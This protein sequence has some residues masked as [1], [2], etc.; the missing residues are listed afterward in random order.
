MTELERK[1]NNLVEDYQEN[2]IL[3]KSI[4]FPETAYE[5]T[6]ATAEDIVEGKT[7]YSN[8][9]LLEG[10]LKINT[11]NVVLDFSKITNTTT[12]NML[13]LNPAVISV[14]EA[15]LENYA[16]GIFSKCSNMKSI[17]NLTLKNATEIA[18]LFHTCSS[19]VTLP[20]FDTTGVIDMRAMCNNCT[21]LVSVPIY[22]TSKLRSG[23]LYYTFGNCPN[24]SDESLNNIMQM[25][26][27]SPINYEGYMCLQ[28]VGL[29]SSQIEKCRTLSNYSAFIAAGWREY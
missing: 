16:I 13:R 21:S 12:S 1:I 22:N 10:L 3:A 5:G 20:E 9:K 27:N 14:S 17:N 24:L 25:C 7:A 28:Q 6:T 2:L 23:G 8:G 18:E 4:G 11:A 26:I 29:S 15:H 19:L